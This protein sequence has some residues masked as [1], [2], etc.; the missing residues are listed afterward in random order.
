MSGV[1]DGQRD[2]TITGKGL[3]RVTG[4]P[5]FPFSQAGRRTSSSFCGERIPSPSPQPLHCI[6]DTS[7]K[8]KADRDLGPAASNKKAK[9]RFIFT[10]K[11]LPID[12]GSGLLR[13]AVD[14]QLQYHYVLNDNRE[15][16]NGMVRGRTHTRLA[17]SSPVMWAF[18]QHVPEIKK[19]SASPMCGIC[20]N[21]CVLLMMV[22]HRRL[23]RSSN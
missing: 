6:M 13:L 10:V 20:L 3:A 7:K 16:S 9:V 23:I 19:R 15:K 11:P 1:D 12:P 14:L 21:R 18:G 5:Q 17:E 22:S 2:A 4:H 8:R